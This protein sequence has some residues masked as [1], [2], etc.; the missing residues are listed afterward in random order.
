MT[1]STYFAANTQFDAELK[2][3]ARLQ[4]LFDPHTFRC[5][6]GLCIDK[7]WRCLDLGAGGGSV[8]K[9]LALR[10]G[11]SGKVV[12][13]DLN[14]RFLS[15]LAADNVDVRQCDIRSDEIEARYYDLAFTRL[16]L[17]HLCGDFAVMEKL[18]RS[19]KPGGWLVIEDVDL[20]TWRS[21]A[22]EQAQARAF[23][24]TIAE[25]LRHDVDF[26]VLD[27]YLG[28]RLPSRFE[29]LGM[30]DIGV[31]CRL[32]LE[33]GGSELSG[34]WH[35]TIAIDSDGVVEHGY[36]TRERVDACL[37]K[38]PAVQILSNSG[39]SPWAR[40]VDVG[41]SSYRREYALFLILRRPRC[42]S[43]IQLYLESDTPYQNGETRTQQYACET[44][45]APLAEIKSAGQNHV[46]VR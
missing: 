3:L 15:D 46:Q 10:V 27:P 42:T 38:G 9:S 22:A 32:A 19:L 30:T 6:E 39:M 28:G 36:L 43:D 25:M 12:S 37:E 2:R 45:I 4:S 1:E 35:D 14:P 18:V 40:T 5:L 34:F 23:D 8:S 21:S 31:T 13:L 11:G 44:F 17:I 41:W 7:E 33:K 29:D 16:V 24:S 20:V 26:G